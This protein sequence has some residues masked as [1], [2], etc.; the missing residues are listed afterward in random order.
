MEAFL[1]SFSTVALAEVGDRTQLLALL[2]ATRYRKPWPIVAAIFAATVA[3]HLAAGFV[4][5]WFGRLLSPTL[6]DGIVGISLVMTGLWMLKPDAI[7][8]DAPAGS[9]GIFMT[10]LVAFFIGEIGDKT[11]IAT[12]ALAAGYANLSAVVAGSISGMMV[13]DVPVV[14]AG[15]AF[16]ARIPA[17]AIH[18]VASGVFALVGLVFIARAMLHLLAPR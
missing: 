1:V 8:D 7:E 11:Q 5:V 17:R 9:A 10:T 15:S 13:A 2:L 6:L 12:V 16:A 14:F 18:Y 3:N 4:G